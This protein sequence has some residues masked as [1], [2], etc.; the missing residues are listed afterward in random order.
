MELQFSYFKSQKMMLLKCCIQHAGKFGK[1]SSGH[2]TGKGQF[3]LQS[4]RDAMPKNV[5]TMAKL[6]SFHMW[7]KQCLKLCRL[8][9]NSSWIKNFQIVKVDFKKTEEPEM[10]L[11]HLLDHRKSKRIPEKNI[12]L[13]FTDYAKAFNCVDYNKLWK[14]LQE[15][16]TSLPASWEICMQ[17]KK[18]QLEPDME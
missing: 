15:Y 8:E 5:Q 11:T 3:S 1:L 10:K 2:R 18:Q 7:A 14:I 12:S 6:H 13:C 9:I 16:Q 17:V 4:Q